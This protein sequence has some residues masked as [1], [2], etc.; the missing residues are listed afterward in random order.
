VAVGADDGEIVE[1]GRDLA[2]R[3]GQGFEMMHVGVA[4]AEGPIDLL[5]AKAAAGHLAPQL[6]VGGA[7]ER[8][9]DLGLAEQGFPVAAFGQMFADSPLLRRARR[10]VVD[11]GCRRAEMEGPAAFELGG[12]L[13]GDARAGA[14]HVG[15]RDKVVDGAG[16][17]EV[18]GEGFERGVVVVAEAGHGGIDD[19]VDVDGLLALAAFLE[20]PVAACITPR[21]GHA[22]G[23][24]PSRLAA[25]PMQ[26]H[27]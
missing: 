17:D 6:A 14:L 18:G 22:C 7:C 23:D 19:P 3:G 24:K 26:K 4:A 21:H 2:G 20:I 13:G 27:A 15:P 9:G 5:E 12:R 1:R 8:L 10:G 11:A 25:L 16:G